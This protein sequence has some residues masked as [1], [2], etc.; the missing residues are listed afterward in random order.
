MVFSHVEPEFSEA[1]RNRKFQGVVG[2]NV[3]VDA[4][5]EVSDITIAHPLG[6]GLDDQAVATIR[7][8]RFSAA[9]R[10]G[11]PVAI[12][13]FVESRLRYVRPPICL[14]ASSG[15]PYKDPRR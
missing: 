9:K 7:T 8:W 5:G 15:D 6:M 14:R 2:L 11:Q 1:A 10:D 4:T 13:V 3:T 12:R